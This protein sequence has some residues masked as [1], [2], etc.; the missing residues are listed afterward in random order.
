MT[1][2]PARYLR[3]LA[4]TR[5]RGM[6]A[7]SD[8]EA[9]RRERLLL[10]GMSTPVA[11]A[12]ESVTQREKSRIATY[13]APD[14]HA[15]DR[16]MDQRARQVGA[17]AGEG[18]LAA[19]EQQIGDLALWV[20]SPLQAHYRRLSRARLQ[21][22]FED[23]FREFFG[24]LGGWNPGLAPYVALVILGEREAKG[25]IKFRDEEDPQLRECSDA[26]LPTRILN[27]ARLLKRLAQG[28]QRDRLNIQPPASKK[29]KNTYDAL[30]RPKFL[31]EMSLAFAGPQELEPATLMQQ[32][33]L[34]AITRR[35]LERLL[36]RV[37][38]PPQAVKFTHR[39][40]TGAATADDNPGVMALLLRNEARIMAAM[41]RD[42]AF[43][44]LL[45]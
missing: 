31:A 38:L 15:L 1:T 32:K 43:R 7:A 19:L 10:E 20:E 11:T 18:P 37:G 27:H 42:P 26:K 17:A 28:G 13:T 39:L 45:A 5:L 2:S 35:D 40:V 3:W 36:R 8:P 12:L 33:V 34:E 41:R 25:T 24:Y 44:H 30:A 23:Y 29:D 9:E 22:D 14:L 21:P 4:R 6:K 16:A